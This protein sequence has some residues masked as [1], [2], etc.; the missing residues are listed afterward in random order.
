MVQEKLAGVSRAAWAPP[1]HRVLVA[2]DGSPGAW[3]ALRYAIAVAGASN[4]VLTI[5]AVLNDPPPWVVLPP[6]ATPWT[7]ESLRRDA[8]RRVSRALAAARDEVPAEISVSTALLE[9]RTAQ[10]LADLADGGCYDLVVAG[11][12]RCRWPRRGVTPA[13]VARCRT[14]VIAVDPAAGRPAP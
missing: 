14:S 6:M 10:A 11:Q 12:S 7:R 8:E 13:L 1:V 2:F 5:A 4:A 9:G 3:A